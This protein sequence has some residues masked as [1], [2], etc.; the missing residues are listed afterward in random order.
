MPYYSVQDGL[1]F[2]SYLPGNLRKQRTFRNQLVVPEVLVGQSLHAHHDHVLFA[3]HLAFRPAYD[4]VRQKYWR[5]TIYHIYA[6][7]RR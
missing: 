3:G 7:Y 6:I 2:K 4:K 1:S 5:S